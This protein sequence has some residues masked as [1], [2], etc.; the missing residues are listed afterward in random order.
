MTQALWFPNQNFFPGR[1]GKIPKWIILHGTAGGNSAEGIAQYFKDTEGTSNPVSS[2]YIIG[3]QGEVYQCVSVSDGAWANGALSAGHDSWWDGVGNPN[4]V[5]I[6]IE[7]VKPA[8]DNSS[9]LT[10]LQKQASFQLIDSI[11]QQCNIPLRP[12]DKDGGITGH[13]SIDPV[14]RARCP[15]L[16]PLDELFSLGA[17]AMIELNTPGI[18]QY[19]TGTDNVYWNCIQTKYTIGH[20]MLDYYRTLT[21]GNDL[22][23]LSILGLPL[24]NETLV[25]G[26]NNTGY[27]EQAFERGTVVYDPAHNLDT[28]P[29]AGA[30][31]IKHNGI[32]TVGIPRDKIV[33]IIAEL[34]AL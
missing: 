33:S 18:S 29:G 34:Q 15:G 6:S 25:G 7:H 10:A 20:A 31:Y 11:C 8:T 30:V 2:H 9:P 27:I 12:A 14:N 23:G 3:L 5:T 17:R 19:F 4:N 26:P 13:Y 21:A 1:W 28:P 24:G 32:P 16:Y 22:C